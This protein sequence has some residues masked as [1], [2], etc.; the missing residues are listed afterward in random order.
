[1]LCSVIVA[2]SFSPVIG[3]IVDKVSPRIT[4]PSAFLIRATSIAMF[5]FI[6][7]PAS[8]FAYATGT[9]LVFGTTCE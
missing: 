9:L 1:M 4:L 5:Y 6:E 7:D 8:P 3:I 2:L